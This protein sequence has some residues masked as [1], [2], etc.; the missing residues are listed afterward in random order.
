MCDATRYDEFVS[1]RRCD[2]LLNHIWHK[3]VDCSL[4]CCRSVLILRLLSMSFMPQCPVPTVLNDILKRPEHIPFLPRHAGL[5]TFRVHIAAKVY[6]P[7]FPHLLESPGF[8]FWKF[9][10]LESPGKI[11]LKITHF[12]LVLMENKQK[13]TVSQ[14]KHVTTFSTITLTI[15]VRLQ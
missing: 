8:F 6:F 4:S 15:G 3:S 5:C 12:V 11:S 1:R 14:K 10:D 2:L 7:G 13:Y 9:Q